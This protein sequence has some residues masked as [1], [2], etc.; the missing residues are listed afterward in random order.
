MFSDADA[1][2]LYDLMYPWDGIRFPG[3]AFYLGLVM[4][5]PSVLDV[6]CGTGALLHQARERGH[7]GRLAGIDPN[8]A[9]LARARRRADIEW[10]RGVAADAAWDREFDLATMTGHAFQCLVDDDEL[11]ASLAAVR[12]ALREGGRFAFETR[13]PQARAWE[14]WTPANAT[15]VEW[16]DGRMLRVSHHVEAVIGDVVTF[17]ETTAEAGGAVLRVDRTSLRFLDVPALI[18]FLEEAGFAVEAQYGDWARGP[19]TPASREIVTIAR[20]V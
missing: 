6:G 11:R 12:A 19:L 7:A 10:V 16:A 14:G 8:E 2:A 4:D 3:D 1:A 18:A 5:A 15:E 9:A 17:T 13:H 20:R